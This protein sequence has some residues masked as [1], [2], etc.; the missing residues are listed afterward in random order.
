MS[1]GDNH[2]AI[3]S[4]IPKVHYRLVRVPLANTDAFLAQQ[5]L[6]DRYLTPILGA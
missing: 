1:F 6:L 4:V 5:S 2:L 3:V